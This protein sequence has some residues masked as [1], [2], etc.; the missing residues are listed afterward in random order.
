MLVQRCAILMLVM[1]LAA[2][3]VEPPMKPLA[4][5]TYSAAD[6]GRDFPPQFTNRN[7]QIAFS[8]ACPDGAGFNGEIRYTRWPAQSLPQKI[9]SN[10]TPTVEAR[11][12]FF[13][14]D[15]PTK[16]TVDWH[17][18]FA[19]RELFHFYAGNL[20]AQDELQVLEHPALGSLRRALQHDKL[21]TLVEENGR[22]APILVQ[23]VERRIHLETQRSGLYGNAF[24]R[25]SA[26]I[27]KN[28]T[29]RLAPP[30]VSN[31]LAIEAPAGGRGNYTA[32]QIRAIL[33]TAFTG[34]KAARIAS[35]NAGNAN[36]RVSIHTGFWGC[37][38]YG[39]NRILMSAL[40]LLAARMAE[41]DTLVFH[42]GDK[43]GVAQ[44]NQAKKLVDELLQKDLDTEALIGEL[45][46]RGFPWGQ[47][48][49]N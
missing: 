7:K 26:D 27:V 28:A 45:A 24:A 39:G 13:T 23:G 11:P 4:T 16:N 36:P 3:T 10:K 29:T 44:F 37:G 41:V 48:D 33:T 43:E 35:A 47:S 22:P 19:D 17:L 20:L 18:N 8:I 30:T 31:I 25:A 1:P 49:G 14:Y 40:Q 46:R 15:P 9:P 21:S 34:F 42:A 5:K 6:L 12:D 2:A 38:A 32:D